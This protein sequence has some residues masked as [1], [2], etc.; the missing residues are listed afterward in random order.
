M[1][2][3]TCIIVSFQQRFFLVQGDEIE[4]VISKG[5]AFVYGCFYPVACFGG[6]PTGDRFY[7]DD[8]RAGIYLPD[9]LQKI[10]IALDEIVSLRLM[11]VVTEIIRTK[12]DK[13]TI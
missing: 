9:C 3:V 1:G 8:G 10:F 11:L 13:D 4:I 2:V 12:R 5:L 7:D 6:Q